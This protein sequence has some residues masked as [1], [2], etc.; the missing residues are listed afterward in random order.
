MKI[1]GKV[2]SGTTFEITVSKT[3]VNFMARS[4]NFSG[5]EVK[6]EMEKYFST[7][8]QLCEI[9]FSAPEPVRT[10][11]VETLRTHLNAAVDDI[12]ELTNE[13]KTVFRE[14]I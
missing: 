6:T 4:P 9:S 13:M 12:Q 14:K 8:L 11:F 5:I 10:L 1:S 3:I 7:F 2:G